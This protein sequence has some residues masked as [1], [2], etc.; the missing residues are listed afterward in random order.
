MSNHLAFVSIRL[1]RFNHLGPAKIRFFRRGGQHLIDKSALKSK[2]D[3]RGLSLPTAG[4]GWASAESIRTSV[5]GGDHQQ[6]VCFRL[7]SPHKRP[8]LRQRQKIDF[9]HH[10]QFIHSFK[11]K[12]F[13]LKSETNDAGQLVPPVGLG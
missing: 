12:K 5:G 8:F 6:P 1:M 3:D 4:S 10:R 13:N 11:Q 9:V 2:E 7:P